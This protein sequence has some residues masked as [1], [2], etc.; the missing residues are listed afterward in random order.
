MTGPASDPLVVVLGEIRD[1]LAE[2]RDQMKPPRVQP[3][4]IPTIARPERSPARTP[5]DHIG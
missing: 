5:R 3:A 1:V 2:I 4:A